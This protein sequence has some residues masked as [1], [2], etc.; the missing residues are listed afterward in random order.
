MEETTVF[1]A[2]FR[3]VSATGHGGTCILNGVVKGD[4][5]INRGSTAVSRYSREYYGNTR[6][7]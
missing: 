7:Y 5:Y 6:E 1:Q 2:F 3:G 4:G